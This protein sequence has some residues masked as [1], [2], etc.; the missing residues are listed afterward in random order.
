MR[1]TPGMILTAYTRKYDDRNKKDVFED[2]RNLNQLKNYVS[3]R[4][5]L[6]KLNSELTAKN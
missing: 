2:N 5:L 6:V 3:K 1:Q 4:Y